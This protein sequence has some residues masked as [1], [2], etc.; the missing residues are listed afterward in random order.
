MD[1]INSQKSVL[2]GTPHNSEWHLQRDFQLKYLRLTE[3]PWDVL[4]PFRCVLVMELPSHSLLAFP[5]R[6]MT[7]NPQSAAC[8]LL[9]LSSFSAASTS[10]VAGA[11]EETAKSSSSGDMFSCIS[12]AIVIITA[13]NK[14]WLNPLGQQI[15][16]AGDRSLMYHSDTSIVLSF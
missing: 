12:L 5:G 3:I 16:E 10:P 14:K 7:F 2:I 1:S 4:W 13:E 8:S 15:L 6:Q 9:Q 11:R